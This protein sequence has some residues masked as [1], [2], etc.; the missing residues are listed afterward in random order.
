MKDYMI[1]MIFVFSVHGRKNITRAIDAECI[2]L[3][4]PEK[5]S[6]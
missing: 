2:I 1:S 3:F 5:I 4:F 6:G